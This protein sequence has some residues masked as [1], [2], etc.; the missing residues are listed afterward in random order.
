ML[1]V[2][3]MKHSATYDKKR[4]WANCF[5]VTC[6]INETEKARELWAVLMDGLDKQIDDEVA[7]KF[8]YY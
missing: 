6:F 3:C 2:T 4:H 7:N 5:S 8:M 1:R